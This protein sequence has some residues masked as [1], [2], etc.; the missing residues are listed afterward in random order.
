MKH[1]LLVTCAKGLSTLLAREIKS[2]GFEPVRVRPHGVYVEESLEAIYCI[3]FGSRI[4]TRV[5]LPLLNFRCSDRDELYRQV[6]RLDWLAYVKPEWSFAIDA[7]L[8]KQPAGG[9]FRNTLFVAQVVKDAICD[10]HKERNNGER[11]AVKTRDPDVQL[12]L[13]IE[14]D[15]AQLSFD[16]S[17]S[18]LF[19][20][21]YRTEG[22]VAPIQETLAAAVLQLSGYDGTQDLLDPFCGSGT[23]LSEAALISS[24]T[25][26]G[27]FRSAWGFDRLPQHDPEVW[28]IVKAKMLAKCCKQR[29]RLLGCDM[30]PTAVQRAKLHLARIGAHVQI[31]V[32][33]CQ[34]YKPPFEPQMVITNPPYGERLTEV[35]LAHL[36]TYKCPV[37]LLSRHAKPLPIAAEY[38]TELVNGGLEIWLHRYRVHNRRTNTCK[39][40]TDAIL[41]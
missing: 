10:Q 30:N 35:S 38:S 19:Q 29:A 11:P 16:T 21:G 26:P 27:A 7:H 22:G 40:K 4:A 20:R 9:A 25:P 17:G 32:A 37:S 2:L 15:R 14:G 13:M 23:L 34:R 8:N 18:P 5:L 31:D 41:V 24:C 28:S 36:V 33:D 3:N 6:G 12:H 1:C 39:Q